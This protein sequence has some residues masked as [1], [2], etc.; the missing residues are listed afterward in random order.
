[1]VTDSF[2]FSSNL[3]VAAEWNTIETLLKS[4]AYEVKWISCDTNDLAQVDLT[5]SF[6]EIPSSGDVMS[7]HIGM[8][9]FRSLGRSLR[10]ES[11]SC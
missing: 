8:T 3:T 2:S 1:M 4:M 7:P 9:L 6:S 11:N 10:I 5:W